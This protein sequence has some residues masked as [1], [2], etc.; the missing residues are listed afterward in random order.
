ML[1]PEEAKKLHLRNNA[2]QIPSRLPAWSKVAL[3][4]QFP[5]RDPFGVFL[6]K[7]VVRLFIY[8]LDFN[9]FLEREERKE[10]ERERNVMWLPLTCPLLG[11]WPTSQ[12]CAPIGNLTSDPLV[13]RSMLN[14]LS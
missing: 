5:T 8:L 14:P 2:S 9:L 6:L 4:R 1:K 10:K 13:P 12:A 7:N 3:D 11:T